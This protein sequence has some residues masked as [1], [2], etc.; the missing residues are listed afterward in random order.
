[1]DSLEY[2]IGRHTLK[3][4][5]QLLDDGVPVPIGRKP[6]E[7]LSV[8]AKAEGAL[9]TKDELM[10][11][12][13]PDSIVEDNAIQVH[14]GALRKAL[15]TDAELLST[16]HGLGYRLAA[17]KSLPSTEAGSAGGS[18]EV[19][20]KNRVVMPVLIAAAAIVVAAWAAPLFWARPAHIPA[21]SEARFAVLPFDTLSD[22]PQVR[23][24]AD[25]LAEEIATRLI[26]NRIQVV[27]RDTAATLRGPDRDRK[28][29]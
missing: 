11:A 3:P 28:V 9:V 5:R 2:R 29:A 4:S 17:R 21:Q 16:V 22:G 15:G 18:S 25:A 24:F 19:E 23:H 27:S 10:A 20:P 14:I 7:L 26:N 1:M 12:V 6:L 8:L 13:W